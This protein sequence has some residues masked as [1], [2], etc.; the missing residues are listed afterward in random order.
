[1]FVSFNEGTLILWEMWKE[2][3]FLP[4][5]S[6]DIMYPNKENINAVPNHKNGD[7]YENLSFTHFSNEL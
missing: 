7:Y 5:Q 2:K 6:I 3:L 1:M 4:N